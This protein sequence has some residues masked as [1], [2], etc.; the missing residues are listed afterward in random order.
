MH[1]FE[2]AEITFKVNTAEMYLDLLTAHS[3]CINDD[4]FL[5]AAVGLEK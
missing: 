5:S 4:T 2:G 3:I 1:R